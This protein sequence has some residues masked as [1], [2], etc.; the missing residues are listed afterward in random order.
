MKRFL[1]MSLMMGAMCAALA[2]AALAADEEVNPLIKI[3]L[4]PAAAPRPALKYQLLPPLSD[5][6]P[7]NAVTQYLKAPHEYA[8][9]YS[10]KKFWDA[11]ER[12]TGLPLP[13]LRKEREGQE[14]YSWITRPI[15]KRW[16]NDILEQIE[17]GARCESCDW[18]LPIRDYDLDR[19][20]LAEIQSIRQPARI[21]AARIRIEIAAGE[22]DEAIHDLQTGF[23]LGRHV[24]DGPLDIQCLVGNSIAGVMAKQVEA[25]VQEPGAPN[26]YWALAALPQPMIDFRPGLQADIEKAY[27]AHPEL[28]DLDKRHYPA[29]RWQQLLDETVDRWLLLTRVDVPSEA[30][31]EAEHREMLKA[32]LDAYPEAKQFLVAKGRSAAEVE[33]MPQA[34]AVL[35]YMMQTYDEHRDDLLKWLWLPFPEALKRF[36]QAEK[37]PGHNPLAKREAAHL[38]SSNRAV[39][40]IKRAICRVARNIAALEILEAIRMYG[41]AH[42]GKLPE[43]LADITEVPIPSDPLRGEPFIYR[44]EENTAM[45]E[46]PYPA[47]P[48]QALRYQ[49]EFAREGA[50]P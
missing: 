41:A 28:R 19:L 30:P 25:F 14:L 40:T 18:A 42:D 34:Q 17:T 49:I 20:I 45:L 4:H 13:E 46:S 15:G 39:L 2:T 36:E 47:E 3:V 48:T 8:K 10:D 1:G 21:F 9:L 38:A 43:K 32:F 50:K 23:A 44:L 26:L 37:E 24:A 22:F 33:A 11:I 27:L 35:L 31:S 12:W 29:E 6:R 16:G 7:G 5:R